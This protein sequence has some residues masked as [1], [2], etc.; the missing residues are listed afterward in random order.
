[1]RPEEREDLLAAYALGS[2]SG[3]ETAAVEDVVRADPSAATQLAA[4]HEIVDLIALDVPLHRADPALRD[5][6][7]R[8]ARR[9]ERPRRRRIPVLQTLAAAALIGALVVAV[10]WGAQLQ[11]DLDDLNE[12]TA[13][14]QAVVSADAKRLDALDREQVA[15]GDQALRL[16]L[17]RV[18]DTQQRIVAILADPDVQTSALAGT[19]AGHGAS[20]RY[21]W[22]ATL[23]AGVLIARQLPPLPLG[24]V[25]EFWLDDGLRQISAGTFVPSTAGDVQMLIELEF[26]FQPLSVAVAPAPLGGAERLNP[27][28]VLAGIVLP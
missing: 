4:Y 12:E 7:L 20:G 14:L 22:S 16:E 18:L 1:M 6:V 3:A 28:L 23:G 27:P 9:V 15:G 21:L 26:P 25:Y 17:Q 19:E 5:R 10:G 13:A 11:R 24:T 8:A 2:L